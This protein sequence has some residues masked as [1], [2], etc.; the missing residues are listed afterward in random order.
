MEHHGPD[1]HSPIEHAFDP[2]TRRETEPTITVYVVT[3]V[4]L[5]GPIGIIGV[6]ADETDALREAN[7]HIQRKMTAFPLIQVGQSN[8]EPETTDA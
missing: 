7:K 4:S 6:Y 8:Q 5:I 2:A 1:E 3:Q